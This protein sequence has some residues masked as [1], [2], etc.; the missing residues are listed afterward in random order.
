MDVMQNRNT[1][2]SLE[3]VIILVELYVIGL[4]KISLTITESS[5]HFILINIQ[6]KYF[7][8]KYEKDLSTV[9]RTVDQMIQKTEKNIAW[10]E[11]YYEEISKWLSKQRNV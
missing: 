9:T 8:E 7:K 11:K 10:M 4:L 1:E 6:I 5:N 2:T 3:E